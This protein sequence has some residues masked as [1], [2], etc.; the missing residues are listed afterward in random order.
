MAH[1]GPSDASDVHGRDD[2]LRDQMGGDES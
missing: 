1:A 2:H